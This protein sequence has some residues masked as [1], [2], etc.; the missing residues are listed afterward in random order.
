MKTT[1]KKP[2][3]KLQLNKITIARLDAGKLEKIRGGKLKDDGN[4]GSTR[5][6]CEET[7]VTDT[8]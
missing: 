5:P 3:K 4:L 8:F 6:A 1:T 7:I 2:E